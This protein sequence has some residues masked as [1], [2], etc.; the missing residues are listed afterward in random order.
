MVYYGI[1][2]LHPAYFY[3]ATLVICSVIS[4]SIGSSWT[5]AGTIGVGL[6]GLATMVGVSPA[7]TAGAVVSG[8]YV[9]DKISPLSETTVLTAQLAKVDVFTHIRAMLW[10][11]VPSFLIAAIVFTFLSLRE[12][13]LVHNV[14][15]GER[16]IQA[17]SALLDYAVE[18]DPAACSAGTL[19]SQSTGLACNPQ[20]GI[21]RR[22]YGGDSAT[23]SRFTLCQRSNAFSPA[24]IHQRHL[25]GDGEWLFT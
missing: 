13:S 14:D 7:I 8:S 9:G 18:P 3:V 6:V 11:T 5:T 17:E 12:G 16:T 25:A 19:V 10:T 24:R 21:A 20:L 1:H 15:T 2:L 22:H 4:L 23:A